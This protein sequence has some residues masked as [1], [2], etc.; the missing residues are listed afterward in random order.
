M[1]TTIKDY[2]SLSKLGLFKELIE[3]DIDS[4]ISSSIKTVSF[5][6]ETR[7]VKF[8]TEEEIGE[9]TE[10]V[11]EFTIPDIPE[12]LSE[13]VDAGLTA[14]TI[15]TKDE[16]VRAAN[17]HLTKEIV[18]QEE[19]DAL[20]S[21]TWDVN[22]IYM[23]KVDDTK[24]DDKYKEYTVI[25]DAITCIGTTSVDLSNV[26]TDETV[27]EL[28]TRVS[29]LEEKVGDGFREVTEDEIRALWDETTTPDPEEGGEGGGSNP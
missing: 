11:V 1:A 19:L 5:D 2:V 17:G 4:K 26:A 23:V 13:I 3:G 15:A 8:Y 6:E 22:R 7:V 21:E 16:V 9:D 12:V 24:G 20:T 14:E 27:A 29:A 25:N 10:A 28:D 18:T